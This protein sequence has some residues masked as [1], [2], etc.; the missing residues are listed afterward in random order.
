MG[1]VALAGTEVAD[2]VLSSGVA[3]PGALVVRVGCGPLLLLSLSHAEMAS[4][5][6]IASR[7]GSLARAR[8]RGLMPINTRPDA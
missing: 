7:A 6:V 4:N 3:S 1:I 5:R 2:M 8:R